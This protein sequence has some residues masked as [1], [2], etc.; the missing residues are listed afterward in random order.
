MPS[1][2]ARSPSAP[3]AEAE[4]ASRTKSRFLANVSHELRTP[5]NAIIG[6]SEMLSEE[7]SE[8]GR[9][10]LADDLEKVRTAALHQLELINSV[11]DLAKIEAGRLELDVET[12]PVA[13]AR[14]GDDGDREA[15]PREE[16]EHARRPPATRGRGLR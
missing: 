7:A 5:L 10:A 12:F 15:A 2:T 8:E 4:E 11:L 13:P 1:G 16:P 9:T 3:P 6:Y 14:R